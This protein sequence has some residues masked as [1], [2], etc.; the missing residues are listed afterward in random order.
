MK[1]E[2][3]CQNQGAWPSWTFQLQF[4]SSTLTYPTPPLKKV[5]YSR[6]NGPKVQFPVSRLLEMSWITT[7]RASPMNY[8]SSMNVLLEGLSH[9][10]NYMRYQRG[11]SVLTHSIE[12]PKY[13]F[14]WHPTAHATRLVSMKAL[15]CGS[16]TSFWRSLQ[17]KPWVLA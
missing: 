14:Y 16:L 9:G 11:Q 5:H 4:P 1:T 13:V 12:S 2:N 3:N 10:P 17:P 6:D 7:P 15:Q 8:C